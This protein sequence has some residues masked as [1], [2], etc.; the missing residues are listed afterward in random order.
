MKT[1]AVTT[2][3]QRLGYWLKRALSGEDIGIM[4]DGRIIGLR[5]VEVISADYAL[6][7]YGVSEAQLER[8]ADHVE[9]EVAKAR[10]EGKLVE[11]KGKVRGST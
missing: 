7:E 1:L 8:A 4:V 2:A 11:F 6:Q 9:R 5:P 3:R 10:K